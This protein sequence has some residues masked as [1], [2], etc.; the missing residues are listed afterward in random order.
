MPM[1]ARCFNGGP[2][3]G[4]VRKATMDLLLQQKSTT[5]ME[6]RR[7][8]KSSSRLVQ[9]KR[10]T[11]IFFRIKG[12]IQKPRSRSFQTRTVYSVS[13]LNSPKKNLV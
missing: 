12:F 9:A 13:G 3:D 11:F 8:L 6:R 2:G 4:P 5:V 10:Q 1:G 7:I